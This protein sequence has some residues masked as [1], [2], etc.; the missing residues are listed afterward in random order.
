MIAI[1]IAVS[2]SMSSTIA[3]MVSTPAS[4]RCAPAALAGDQLEAMGPQRPE[5]DRLEDAVLADRRGEL[6]SVVSSNSSRGCS[7]FGSICSSGIWRMVFVDRVRREQAH[8]GGRQLALFRE[9]GAAAARKSGL[10]KIDHLPCQF[11]IGARG[12][13]GARIGRD[14]PAGQRRLTELHRV[15]TMLVKTWWSPMIRSSPACRGRAGS[16]RRT[17][18]AARGSA[19]RG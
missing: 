3:G 12:F 4:S 11:A 2:S 15:A 19:G 13:R 6:L 5:Q 8:D 7:G 9:A 14:G 16:R 10:A 1:S 18:A 17:S